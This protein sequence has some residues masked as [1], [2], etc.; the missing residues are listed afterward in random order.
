M[1]EAFGWGSA[2]DISADASVD[3]FDAAFLP[4]AV[5]VAE[6]GFDTKGMQLVM[7]EELRS[8]VLSECSAELGGHCREPAF[9]AVGDGLGVFAW[10]LSYWSQWRAI[11]NSMPRNVI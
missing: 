4:W 6:E 8:I 5:R 11:Q 1:G 3:I 2:G 7:Q 9:E 10:L